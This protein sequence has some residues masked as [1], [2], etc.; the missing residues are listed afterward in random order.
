MGIR[1][2]KLSFEAELDRGAVISDAEEW[3]ILELESLKAFLS[4]V[5][6]VFGS[7][8]ITILIVAGQAVGRRMA[9]YL[10]RKGTTEGRRLVEAFI[11]FLAE[12]GWGRVEVEKYGVE[13][14][15]C[16]LKLYNFAFYRKLEKAWKYCSL[17]RGLAVGFFSE[18]WKTKISCKEVRCVLE[19]HECCEFHLRAE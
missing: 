6:E 13:G 3:V 15:S 12:T 5:W 1:V 2:K 9:K 16:I 4:G 7:G 11:D 10:K 14:R 8:A 19:G 17:F 18:L